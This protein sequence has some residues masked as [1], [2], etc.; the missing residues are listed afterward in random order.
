MAQELAVS[1]LKTH[2]EFLHDLVQQ[3][4]KSGYQLALVGGC[5][6]DAI[7]GRA[8]N[9]LDLTT[10]AKP[11]YVK[12][13]L[14]SWAD[15]VW[16]IGADFGTIAGK[17][18]DTQIE[19]TTYRSDL[20]QEHSRKPEIAF[21]EKIEED[22]IRRDFTINS[23]A[24]E[25]TVDGF[26]LIDPF[27]GVN[28]LAKKIIKTPTEPSISFNEDPLRTLRAARFAAQLGFNIENQTLQAITEF[29]E[30]LKIVSAERIRDEFNK[31]IL[32]EFPR[33][34]LKI[35]V[36]TKL[37]DQFIPEI[38]LLK[39]EIDE[40]H[41]HK[42]VYEHTLTV[43]EQAIN[44]EKKLGEHDLV[45]R[46]AALFHDVGKPK[47]RQLLSGGGV[48]FHHHE[49]VGSKMTKARLKELRYDSQ[50][51]D[52]VSQLVFLHLRFHGY[53]SGEWSDSAVRRYVR[54]AG[55]NL[56]RLHLLT[57]ADCTTRN[58]KKAAQLSQNYDDLENRIEELQKTEEL[59]RIR[60]ELDGQQ[61]MNLLNLKP[62]KAVGIA[63]DFLMEIRLDQGLLGEEEITKILLA[64]WKT[65][66]ENILAEVSKEK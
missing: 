14:N 30:R 25:L 24:L 51:I 57:R 28:D 63:Y 43:L 16:D 59:S 33:N 39:L 19:I 34:G 1:N 49:V 47:T 40:H 66:G 56:P 37:A 36:E 7:L 48:A 62:S 53:G 45:L 42:D 55:E 50:T 29:R 35:L 46:L 9:D 54:D 41:H 2:L 65:N 3:F 44:L 20:Y 5:V 11:E 32:G 4:K 10:D 52:L 8:I 58:L 15:N 13:L 18:K 6:R 12:K 26:K 17:K 64:W 31:L 27:G 61:I 22:L 38:P 23:M 21:S 60:P